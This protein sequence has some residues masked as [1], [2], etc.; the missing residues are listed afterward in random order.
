MA[1]DRTLRN[2]SIRRFKGETVFD[3]ETE[4]ADERPSELAEP[5]QYGALW[6]PTRSPYVGLEVPRA[7]PPR[8][9]GGLGNAWIAVLLTVALA[10]AAIL[11]Y[12]RYGPMKPGDGAAPSAA[13]AGHH[14]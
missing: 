13:S 14:G 12:V 1:R 4:P 5:T 7:R 9:R 3:W 11:G 2:E 8:K 6:A 10:A